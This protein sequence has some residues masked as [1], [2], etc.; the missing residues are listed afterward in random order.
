MKWNVGVNFQGNLWK[1]TWISLWETFYFVIPG[2]TL[3]P[4]LPSGFPL[5]RE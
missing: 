1:V 2:L 3:N 4:G 5:A